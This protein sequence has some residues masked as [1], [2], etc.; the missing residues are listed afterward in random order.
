MINRPKAQTRFQT[1]KRSFYPSQ[2]YICLPNLFILHIHP[3][4]PK[5]IATIEFDLRI[6]LFPFFPYNILGFGL[7]VQLVT[8]RRQGDVI[9]FRS[10]GVFLPQPPDF[11][12]HLVISL[13]APFLFKALTSGFKPFNNKSLLTA[14]YSPIFL[15]SARASAKQPYFIIFQAPS[16]LYFNISVFILK[17]HTHT[18]GVIGLEFTLATVDNNVMQQ[19]FPLQVF[20]IIFGRNSGVDDN[21]LFL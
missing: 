2:H 9:Q 16:D 4:S 17:D 18:A 11:F 6:I 14:A 20:D 19:F 8:V 15:L 21:S 10:L 5:D 12:E 3:I 1:A 7:R 13:G